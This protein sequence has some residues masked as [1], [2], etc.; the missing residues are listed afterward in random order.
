MKP[1]M[2][3]IRCLVYRKE[4]ENERKKKKFVNYVVDINGNVIP[5]PQNGWVEDEA[6][7]RDCGVGE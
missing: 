6:Y 5:D 1:V 3:Y 7:C 2:Y 4:I